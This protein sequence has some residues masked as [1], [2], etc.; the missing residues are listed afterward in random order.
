MT[1]GWRQRP[2]RIC[3][4]I[5][6]QA[7]TNEEHEL[8]VR[9]LCECL[10]H[11]VIC[12]TEDGRGTLVSV[13][14]ISD[15]AYVQFRLNADAEEYEIWDGTVKPYLRQMGSMTLDERFEYDRF[16][17]G[18]NT[19]ENHSNEIDWLN[20]HHF[21]YRVPGL[22]ERGLATEAPEGMYQIPTRA[23]DDNI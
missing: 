5:K 22:I 21:D 3:T 10:P 19:L 2:Q 13:E 11:N 9:A 7:M 6:M 17:N 14:P 18:C 23:L 12:E 1:K 20:A 4:I 15:L 16:V 8:L